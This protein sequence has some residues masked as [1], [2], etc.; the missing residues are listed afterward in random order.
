M[1]LPARGRH[2]AALLP[3]GRRALRLALMSGVA[4]ATSAIPAM[5]AGPT[6]S[7][8]P[9]APTLIADGPFGRVVGLRTRM[10]APTPRLDE[11]PVLDAWA[12][13]TTVAIR[14]TDGTLA[15]WRAVALAEPDLDPTTAVD[16]GTGDGDAVIGLSTSGLFLVRV[17]G[18]IRPDGGAIE[19][20]WW[21]RVAVPDRDLPPDE[22]GPPPP[23]I[24]LSSGDDAVALEQ[25][26][27]CFLGTCGDIGGI[28]PPDLLPTVRTIP[29]APLALALADG[30][31]LTDWRIEATPV[32]GDE[33]DGVVLG[34]GRDTWATLAWS[35]AP[36][37]GEWLI[38][39]SVTLDRERGHLDGY[40]R[41]LVRPPGTE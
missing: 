27:G 28:S 10:D 5:A 13:G 39:A 2:P 6:P 11:L 18:T 29:G 34:E 36:A 16:L 4:I 24:R 40:G 8:G 14:P 35:P 38:E 31:G 30:S 20:T 3:P 25:G 32:E 41:L 7:A 9:G 21:W 37:D 15:P 22:S 26:S 23:A 33:R 17:D 12:R 1:T 19:G